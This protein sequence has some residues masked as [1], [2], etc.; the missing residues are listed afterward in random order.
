[1]IVTTYEVSKDLS[2][3][4][5][6]LLE[7]QEYPDIEHVKLAIEYVVRCKADDES[8]EPLPP[9]SNP[10]TLKKVPPAFKELMK[11]A[12]DFVIVVD[13]YFWDESDTKQKKANLGRFL[14]RIQ[15]DPKDD[16]SFKLSLRPWDIQENVDTLKRFGPYSEKL[17][18]VSE[19]L[20]RQQRQI[21]EMADAHDP[22]KE[23]APARGKAA[24]KAESA[25]P[26]DEEDPVPPKRGRRPAPDAE[27]EEPPAEEEEVPRVRA[28]VMPVKNKPSPLKNGK[29]KGQEN[30]V[31]R[32]ARVPPPDPEPAE[33]ETQE[34][35]PPE[36]A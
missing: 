11:D 3:F 31:T 16:G 27:K 5:A 26:E 25:M 6:K 9:K 13:K 18:I 30:E 10:V 23:K 32:P 24:A 20:A 21:L 8:N 34:E 29:A 4:L 2:S 19:V 17:M 7:E 28:A 33:S 1:M 12:P 36:P 22:Q 15:A 35:E 14:S